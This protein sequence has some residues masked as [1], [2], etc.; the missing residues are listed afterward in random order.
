MPKRI[1]TL[2]FPKVDAAKPKTKEYKM[3]DGF[4]LHLLITPSGGKLWRFQ[5][6]FAKK[7]KAL[8]FGSF[9][10]ISIADARKLRDEARQQVANGIDP[11]AVKKEQKI[12]E[13]IQVESDSNTFEK[14]AREWHEFRKP[15]W[16][17]N[18]ANRL[19]R[20]LVLDV[21]DFIGEKPI[22]AIERPELVNLLQRIATRSSETAIRMKI[23]FYGIFRYAHNKGMIKLN[24]AMEFR[25]VIPKV[26]VNHMAAPTVPKK[27]AELMK[28]IDGFTGSFVTMNALKLTPHL[29]VRPGELRHMEWCELNLDA[30]EWNIP[31]HKM[32]M[33]K[34]HLV[35]LS[36]QALDI[37]RAIH[38]L[39]GAGKF[40]FPCHRSP[41]SCMSENTIN[42]CLRRLGFDKT[43]ITAHGFRATAR[44]ML[45]ELLEFR[46]D[47][48]E[49]Q[50][51][52]AVKDANG[53]AY[54][55]TTHLPYRRR[56]MQSWSDYLDGLKNGNLELPFV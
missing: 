50:L 2:S 6:R 41:L 40:V 13:L 47:I 35:P 1:I 22:V 7:Q 36:T 49:H 12:L 11:G 19:L 37:L 55:R 9:P 8:A 17:E 14:V 30:A 53:T 31:G 4:G 29:F 42:A 18:H 33:K 32:K 27:V 16:S 38:P 48:I 10:E 45:D 39:T 43:E 5:Y 26:T 23:A 20:R 51:S 56:M 21:F 44:T 3:S 28:A 15:E 24:P 54:N 46:I 25:D 52:H 34:E